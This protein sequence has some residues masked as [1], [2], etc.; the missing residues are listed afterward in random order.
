MVRRRD[1]H[2]H[3]DARGGS[4]NV[5][6]ET[7]AAIVA[8]I[9]SSAGFA[10]AVPVTATFLDDASGST[11]VDVTVK[12]E[13]PGEADAA[14]AAIDEHFGGRSGVDVVNVS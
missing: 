2:V 1:I 7:A 8:G 10:L 5:L 4:G 13:D 11:G 12:L 14:A 6:L 3:L 9:L